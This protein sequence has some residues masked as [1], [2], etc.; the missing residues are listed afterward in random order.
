MSAG[1]HI[2]GW[3]LFGLIL[4]AF[5]SRAI[6]PAEGK[7]QCRKLMREAREAR[8]DGD[9]LRAWQCYRRALIFEPHNEK[10]S[11]MAA[12]SMFRLNY[13]VDSASAFQGNLALSRIPDAKY[14]LGR[15]RHLQ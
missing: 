10:A 11:E 15:I 14:Y 12:E 2:R 13:S 7:R 9:Y 8:E 1:R 4:G 6:P 5:Y 3:L